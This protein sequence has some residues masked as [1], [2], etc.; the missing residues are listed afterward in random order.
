MDWELAFLSALRNSRP[1]WDAPPDWRAALALYENLPPADAR[2]LDAAILRMVDQDYRNPHS[3]HDSLPFDDIQVNLPAGMVP[4]DLLCIESAILVASERGLGPAYFDF[5][6]LMRQPRWHAMSGRLHFLNYEG[7]AAQRRLAATCSGRHHGALIGLA[8]AE[9][10]RGDG[11]LR[12]GE[13]GKVTNAALTLASTEP[14]QGLASLLPA[15]YRQELVETLTAGATSEPRPL[16]GNVRDVEE[17]LRRALNFSGEERAARGA[18][19][20]ARFGP[21]SAPRAWS[22][23]LR[24]RLLLEEAAERFARTLCRQS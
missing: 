5:N 20:G 10:V 17:S 14:E 24:D 23:A 18:L 7:P 11:D 6:R 13:W 16:L 8:L 19:A 15:T 12:V 1:D 3:S 9:A 4:E 2:I 21:L 22:S